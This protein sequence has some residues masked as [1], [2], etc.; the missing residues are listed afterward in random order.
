MYVAMLITPLTFWVGTNCFFTRSP[1]IIH[2]FSLSWFIKSSKT[3]AT[4]VK[5]IS[6][7]LITCT[8]KGSTFC[9]WSKCC[10]YGISTVNYV[11]HICKNNG[12]SHGGTSKVYKQAERQP[13]MYVGFC[14][15]CKIYI[16]LLQ[17][18]K[19][20]GYKTG[21]GPQ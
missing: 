16:Q 10:N 7:S 3:T 19:S 17:Q 2:N 20:I 8:L 12:Y 6:A 5:A 13:S 15:N 4:A 14:N 11:D 1:T 18:W 21:T 9:W